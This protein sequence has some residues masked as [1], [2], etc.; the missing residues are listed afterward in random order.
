[1]VQKINCK[2]GEYNN[3]SLAAT[4]ISRQIANKPLILYSTHTYSSLS[5]PILC[6]NV[7]SRSSAIGLTYMAMG[8]LSIYYMQQ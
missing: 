4:V 3:Q 7:S 6:T 8:A 2:M 1:M 5:Y